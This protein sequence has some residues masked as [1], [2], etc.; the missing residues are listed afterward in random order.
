MGEGPCSLQD[1][2]ATTWLRQDKTGIMFPQI[3][4]GFVF[5]IRNLSYY[6]DSSGSRATMD[7]PNL[8]PPF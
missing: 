4:F 2:V 6:Y 3:D 1:R 5:R 8:P 7:R